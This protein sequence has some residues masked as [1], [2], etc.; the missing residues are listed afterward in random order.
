MKLKD[1]T[2][3]EGKKHLHSILELE[4]SDLNNLVT[5]LK[6]RDKWKER[7]ILLLIAIIAFSL[8]YI[9]IDYLF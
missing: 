1:Y 5:K 8:P 9:F 3:E 4:K 6:N 2:S 7:V